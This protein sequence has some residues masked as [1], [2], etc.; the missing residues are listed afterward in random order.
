[1]VCWSCQKGVNF[2]L[3]KGREY[4]TEIDCYTGLGHWIF[5]RKYPLGNAVKPLW[6]ELLRFSLIILFQHRNARYLCTTTA[7]KCWCKFDQYVTLVCT[8]LSYTKICVAY[9]QIWKFVKNTNVQQRERGLD[10]FLSLRLR[11][12][13]CWWADSAWSLER[14]RCRQTEVSHQGSR[15]IG[16]SVLIDHSPVVIGSQNEFVHRQMCVPMCR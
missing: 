12:Q 10:R 7:Q 1:M 5:I 9:G 3:V 15:G 4:F 13:V 8:V 16:T 2:K 11:L 14:A 6:A